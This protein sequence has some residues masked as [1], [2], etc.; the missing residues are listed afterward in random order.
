MGDLPLSD[1]SQALRYAQP[2]LRLAGRAVSGEAKALVSYCLNEIVLPSLPPQ[3]PSSLEGIERALEAMLAG[4]VAA[5]A[6]DWGDGWLRRPLANGSFTA[7]PVS[8]VQFSKAMNAL[9]AIGVIDAIA[10]RKGG[11]AGTAYRRTETRLRL[12]GDGRK[13]AESFGVTQGSVS[14]HFDMPI[15]EDI[16]RK[17]QS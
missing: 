5:T 9:E 7:E 14:S 15:A 6:A 11:A 1:I 13:L 12:S 4:L 17:D 16:K 10:G 3:R 8:R 2:T